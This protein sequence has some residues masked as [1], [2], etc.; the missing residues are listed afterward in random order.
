MRLKGDVRTKS[1]PEGSIM[2]G[3]MFYES[4]TLCGHYLHSQALRNVEEL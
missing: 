1:H 2:E 4:L 3:S